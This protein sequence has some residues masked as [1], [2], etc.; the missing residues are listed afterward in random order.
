MDWVTP[1]HSRSEVDRA[2]QVLARREAGDLDQ[3]LT[4]IGNWRGSHSFPLNTLKMGLRTR[5]GQ[6][7]AGAL[8]AQRIKRL[9]SIAF[10][11]ERQPTMQLSQMQDIGGC[12]AVLGDVRSLTAVRDLTMRSR[13]KHYLAK[14]NDYLTAPK[15]S[16]YRGIHLVYR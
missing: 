13:M 6:L 14:E 10:K 2:G 16:G 4:V 1:L 7:D 11:L 8:V 3:A 15:P 5:A 12:R 9:S